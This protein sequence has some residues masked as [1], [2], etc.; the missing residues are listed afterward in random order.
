MTGKT[1]IDAKTWW[2]APG[3]IDFHSHGQTPENY[4]FK[5]RDG[6]TTALELEV[7]AWPIPSWYAARIG[8]ALI[9]FG[10]SSG[11]I[12]AVMAV[13]HD[14]GTLLPRDRAITQA[15]YC[16]RAGADHYTY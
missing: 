2:F 8:K 16:R 5:A 14:T 6:V 1:V 15:A 12:P 11:L 9:N 4:R 3:F 10:A 13:L 7:G